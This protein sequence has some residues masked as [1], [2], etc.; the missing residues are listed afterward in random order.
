MKRLLIIAM[1]IFIVSCQQTE[2]TP[3]D[4]CMTVPIRIEIQYDARSTDLTVTLANLKRIYNEIGVELVYDEIFIWNTPDPYGTGSTSSRFKVASEAHWQAH[5]NTLNVVVG[6]S[7]EGKALLSNRTGIVYVGTDT[8]EKMTWQFAHEIGH[9][10]GCSHMPSTECNYI[11]TQRGYE[12]SP[13]KDYP[14]SFLPKE[15]SIIKTFLK[16]ECSL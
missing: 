8:T 13:C 10:L 11:M 12:G 4:P 14:Q 16:T 7:K 6:S 2:D 3:V 15:A 5:R 9:A 1:T